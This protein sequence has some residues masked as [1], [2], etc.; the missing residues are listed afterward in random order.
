MKLPRS[1]QETRF[2]LPYETFDDALRP[3]GLRLREGEEFSP[4]ERL[5]VDEAT[6]GLRPELSL[7]PF[8]SAAFLERSGYGPADVRL[9]VLVTSRERRETRVACNVAL[10]DD[11]P[12]LVGLWSVYRSPMDWRGTFEVSVRLVYQPCRSIGREPGKAWRAGQTLAHKDFLLAP[13][14]KGPGMQVVRV[15]GDEFERRSLPPNTTCWVELADLDAPDVSQAAMCLVHSDVYDWLAVPGVERTPLG[16]LAMGWLAAEMLAAVLLKLAELGE[17][18]E[19]TDATP[20]A[21]EQFLR[22]LS[23][24]LRV[25]EAD[26]LARVRRDRLYA[27]AAVQEALDLTGN[28]RQLLTGAL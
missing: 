2:A 20:Q 1:H 14:R 11:L 13:V 25:S 12:K 5:D 26:L 23:G 4:E 19:A 22:R 27:F 15:T 6:V 8:D 10:S 24:E 17:Q 7:A 28:M 21:F 3:V 18:G 16:R 9:L